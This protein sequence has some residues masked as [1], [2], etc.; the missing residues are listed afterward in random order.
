MTP[1]SS[2]S[3]RG[4]NAAQ[5]VLRVD[6][7]AYFEATENLYDPKYNP[8]GTFPLNI[9]ENKLVWHLL[10]EKMAQIH[11][12]Q[13]IPD[14]VA[15]YTSGKGAPSFRQAVA[16]FMAQFLTKCP[17]DP[18]NLAFSAGATSVVEMTSLILADSGDVAVFPTPCYPVYKQDIGNIAGMERYDL[19]THHNLAD[20]KSG[21]LL[22][23]NHLEKA[24]K[25]IEAK[26]KQ[27]KMLVLTT[28]DNPTGRMY[29]FEQLQTI[30]DWC[31]QQRI[32]LI[33]N[34]IYGLSL[35][36]TK[37]PDI[38]VDYNQEIPF[39]SFAQ[40][41]EQQ[42]SS[43]LHLW[44]AFSK[45][46]G[47]SGF[48]I[49]LVYSLNRAFLQAY[50]NL[51]YSHLVSNYAQWIVQEVLK[52]SRFVQRYIAENQRLLTES[53]VTVVQQLKALN[54][55]YVPSRGS[56]FIWLDLSEFLSANT[57]DAE[58]DFWLAFYKETGILLTPGQGFGHTKR[59][60]FRMVYTCFE[61][62]DLEVAIQRLIVF[63][64]K[65]RMVQ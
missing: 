32:H 11:Q 55:D 9:A 39:I 31:M 16:T 59:G 40:I 53:Y 58:D 36:N 8:S 17:I 61:Q 51:N 19:I 30:A 49:G 27:F 20:I 54:I 50:E 34:E 35:I 1:I 12:N 14:W 3:N 44:Y 63:V 43:Y 6:M 46:F 26:G 18:E 38:Q 4:N 24:K 2:L 7:E 15:A 22:N 25:E 29:T 33:V 62:S 45:D 41:M 42:K 52:D 5:T 57:Q 28:P 10:S 21:F 56:L 48:R 60:L 37:H 65:K 23:I 64:K 47:I 13:Q